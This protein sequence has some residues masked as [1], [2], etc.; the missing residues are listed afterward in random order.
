MN[1]FEFLSP[2][3]FRYMQDDLK[4]KATKYLSEEAKIK[5]ELEVEIA[6]I[7]A[8]SFFG[9]CKKE[10][11]KE[12]KKAAKKI[13]AEMVYAE[14][15]KVKHE[16]KALVNILSAN[17]SKKSK[18][19]IHLG[20]TSCDVLDTAN[21]L[22][23]KRYT[24]K[25][26]LP[27]AKELLRTLIKL[28]LRYKKTLQIGR[29]HGQHAE[30]ITFGFFLAQYVSR[31]GNR[32][33]TI[34][35]ACSKLCGKIS[36][37]VGA[38]N[39]ISLFCDDPLKLEE[40]TLSYLGLKPSESSTQIL[41]REFF[42]DLM[43]ANLSML[44]VVANLADDLRHLQRSEIAEI[45]ECFKSQQVGSSAMPH[46][47]NPISFENIKSIWKAFCPRMITVYMDQISEHQRDLTNSASER[48][49][50]EL[51]FACTYA[52]RQM[53]KTLENLYIDEVK[54]W[55]NL[56]KSD[57]K[58]ASEAL[59]VLLALHGVENAHEKVKRLLFNTPEKISLLEAALKDK[60]LSV[61]LRK[62]PNEKISY[63]KSPEKYVG[64]AEQKTQKICNAWK[65]RLGVKC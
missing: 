12:V 65:K 24:E 40:K 19:F 11:Y 8:L 3:D 54:M 22:R 1:K 42:V 17:V 46:K 30:P 5:H 58:I 13:N 10:T 36:G 27:E 55:E 56:K 14:E 7:R 62:I 44:G 48:F 2:I 39:A 63:I 16:T 35:S 15:A 61:Y 29:T 52:L 57:Q 51:L 50:P 59:Y 41:P 45:A 25:V 49:L 20:L 34:E 43:H 4:E 28:S 9:F 38:Y 18:R 37:A 31:L 33:L 60:E 32:V 21:A 6:Y 53:R 23:Y 26:I 64:I 47:R